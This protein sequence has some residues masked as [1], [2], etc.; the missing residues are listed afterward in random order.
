MFYF[1]ITVTRTSQRGG[2]QKTTRSTEYREF[3]SA[4]ALG[5]CVASHATRQPRPRAVVVK[6]INQATYI[7]RT[8]GNE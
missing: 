5:E 1:Q 2:E 7:R 3:L 6:P 4:D 8:R